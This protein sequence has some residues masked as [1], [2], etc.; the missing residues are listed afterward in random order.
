MSHPRRQLRLGSVSRSMH[1]FDELIGRTAEAV[2][3]YTDWRLRLDPVPLDS[4]ESW[5]DL[6][7]RIEGLLGPHGNDPEKIL[8]I[9]D[10]AISRAVI[11]CDS[12]D[13]SRS[14][15]P[16]PRRAALLFDMVVSCASLQGIF[17]LE[18]AGAVA[19]E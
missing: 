19:A 15:R 16:L 5:E 8:Q 10:E 14:S 17:W 1:E 2:Y 18:A 13:S 12:P 3:R 11:S 6:D 7:A 4:G 9:Y